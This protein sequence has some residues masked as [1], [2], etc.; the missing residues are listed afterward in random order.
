VRGVGGVRGEVGV[1]GCFPAVGRGVSGGL[2]GNGRGWDGGWEG[3][4]EG[5]GR[6]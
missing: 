2:E 5:V 1:V 6:G 4:W 3:D